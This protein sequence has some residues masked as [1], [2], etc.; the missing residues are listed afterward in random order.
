[1]L[2]LRSK[3]IITAV[4]ACAALLV[5]YAVFTSLPA[6]HMAFYSLD[7][8]QGDATLIETP[9]HHRILIDGGPDQ[10]V[11]SQLGAVMP[12]YNKTIDLMVL[13]HPQE[14]HMF[15]LISVLRRYR[16][17][18]VLMT[19]VN[20]NTSTYSEFK[21]MIIDKHI[22]VYQA[23]AGQRVQF[24]DG[25]V[26]DV[27]Y[28]FDDLTGVNFPGDVN[29]ASVATRITYN[30]EQFLV[31]GDAGMMEEINLINS[32]EDIDVDVLKVSHHGSRTSTSALFLEKTSPS[33][34]TISV[35][36]HNKYGHP[37]KETLDRLTAVPGIT[38]F[39]TDQNGRI[40]VDTDGNSLTVKTQR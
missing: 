19:D 2:N 6:T 25:V 30:K 12:F 24:D 39:R 10:S 37:T 27:L 32:G 33:I 4:F 17:G 35:S 21:K 31:M 22:P 16:V 26:L 11:L 7:V 34:V 18:A 40:E 38:I 29:D 13:T 8:G 23:R 9:R 15:G 20:Y 5:W 28:P 3:I 14:D 36:A 1:M